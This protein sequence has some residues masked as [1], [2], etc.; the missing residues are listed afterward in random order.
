MRKISI[1]ALVLLVA[2]TSGWFSP[3]SAQEVQQSGQQETVITP[4]QALSTLPPRASYNPGGKRDPF[5]D[6]IGKGKG[7]SKA[8]VANG[9]LTI[10]NATLV[11]IV[12]T[13]KS[14]GP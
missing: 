3:A 4:Q 10:D 7:G 11:G 13:P 5:L 8:A 6:L 12:K 2:G 14:F 1:L 9:Q